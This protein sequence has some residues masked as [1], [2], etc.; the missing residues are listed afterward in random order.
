MSIYEKARELA[1]A[2][3]NSDELRAVKENEIKIMI[4]PDARKIIEEYQ[5]IQVEAINSGVQYEDLP[6]EK[7]DSMEALEKEMNDNEIVRDYIAASN[8]LNQ[9]LESI[10]M[11]IGSALNGGGSESSCSSCSSAGGCADGGSCGCSH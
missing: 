6:Q 9:I 10:N 7:K 5:A 8:E 3:A 11:I 4:D 1:E 2:I